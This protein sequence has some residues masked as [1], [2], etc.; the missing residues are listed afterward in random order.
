MCSSDLGAG[1]AG[2]AAVVVGG[3]KGPGSAHGPGGGVPAVLYLPATALIAKHNLYAPTLSACA[4]L[5]FA[6]AAASACWGVGGGK[7]AKTAVEPNAQTA[8]T[9]QRF[10]CLPLS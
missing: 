10:I 8:L 2:A 5:A 7:E 3:T 4:V 9:K 1:A 6:N